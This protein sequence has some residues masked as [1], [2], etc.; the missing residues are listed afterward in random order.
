MLRVGV[1]LRNQ[2]YEFLKQKRLLRGEFRG[3]FFASLGFESIWT[4]LA[5]ETFRSSVFPSLRDGLH[6]G[7]KRVVAI[8]AIRDLFDFEKS[9]RGLVALRP[10]MG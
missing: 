9:N 6:R 4:C 1:T 8:L 10:S 7:W 3:L 5:T 2:L